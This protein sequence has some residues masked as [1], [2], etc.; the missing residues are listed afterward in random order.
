[1][2]GLHQKDDLRDL[3][4]R[5]Q[6]TVIFAML[7]FLALMGR[8]CQ[9]QVLES[10]H[11]D[12]RAERNFMDKVDVEAPRG[13]IYDVNG[14]P[15]ATNRS[16]YTL[17]ITGWTRFTLDDDGV[18]VGTPEGKRVAMDDTTRDRILSLIDFI[19]E[20]DR[21]KFAGLVEGLRGDEARGRYAQIARRNLSWEE[22]ARIESRLEALDPW[23][24]IRE[25]S[26]RFYPEGVLTAFVTGQMGNV[27]ARTLQNSP[28]LGYR[29]GDRVGQTGIERQWENYLR[30]RLG[31]RWRV[32]DAR[33]REVGEPPAW[34]G[35]ALPPDRDPIPGQDIYLTLDLD[36]QSVAYEAV[37]DK[38]AGAVVAMEVK[39]GRVLA[40]ASVPAIDPNRY[41]QP[42]PSAEWKAWSRS[43][44]R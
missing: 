4:P 22:Y 42:I 31:E 35:E 37:S 3:R 36:L 15:L 13:R 33:R 12:R 20:A 27:S 43:R 39:T 34:A 38:L 2:S 40:M 23:V 1:M 30:G 8:L 11:Y 29:L 32:V 24:E 9:L 21:D 28:H 26:R 5:F 41:E 25:S 18:V 10:D 14:H 7:A 44:V 17:Y 16:S 6:A 19:D